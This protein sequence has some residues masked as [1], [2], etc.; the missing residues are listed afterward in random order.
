MNLEDFWALLGKRELALTTDFAWDDPLHGVGAAGVSK[1]AQFI[2]EKKSARGIFHLR[3]T[4]SETRVAVEHVI[5]LR[6][7]LIWNQAE[8]RAEKAADF[9]L[10][11]AVVGER[12]GDRFRA[13]R[14]YFGT[15]AVTNGNPRARLGPIAP[16]ERART[17][18]AM[19]AMP[20]VRKYFDGL[21]AGDPSIVNLFEPDGYFREPANNFR[22]GRDQL[23]PHFQGILKIGGVGIEFLTAIQ[24]GRRIGLELQTVEWG[25]K[26]MEPQAGFAVYE[27]GPR[28]LLQASRVYDSVVPP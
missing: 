25:K 26:N 27:L 15:W 23:W 6:D 20:I 3:T 19:D 9:E 24:E 14:V 5:A 2:D 18:A 13:I 12:A 16:D 28:G 1:L 17:K 7:G 11:T 8:D 21:A 22:C 4:S 10:A